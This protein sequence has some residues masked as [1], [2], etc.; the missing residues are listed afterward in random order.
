MFGGCGFSM[1]SIK[2]LRKSQFSAEQTM[3]L[4]AEGYAAHLQA[5]KLD[6]HAAGESPARL[7]EDIP[8]GGPLRRSTCGDSLGQRHG[9]KRWFS[10]ET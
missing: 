9:F 5:G 1:T 4:V 3:S 10:L 8:T 7:T 6:V 2:T